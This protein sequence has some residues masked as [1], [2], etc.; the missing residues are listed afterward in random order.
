MLWGWS[1]PGCAADL[2][3]LGVH[4]VDKALGLGLSGH[5]WA[6][7]APRGLPWPD[8]VAGTT[9]ARAPLCHHPLSPVISPQPNVTCGSSRGHSLFPPCATK[10]SLASPHSCCPV[11]TACLYQ[12][13]VGSIVELPQAVRKKPGSW[14]G[15]FTLSQ[16]SQSPTGS[17]RQGRE[18]NGQTGLEE[19]TWFSHG[20]SYGQR[21]P[22]HLR[23]VRRVRWGNALRLGSVDF[24]CC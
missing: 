24:F 3:C 10:Q 21:S 7:P 18:R 2:L 9:E 1:F 14:K 12:A 6:G 19:R 5:R 17:P 22:E 13:G 8:R 20:A 11:Q 16:V 15:A 4:L 23:A